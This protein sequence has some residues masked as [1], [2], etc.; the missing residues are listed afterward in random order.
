[1][2]NI[3]FHKGNWA[4]ES[5][6][7]NLVNNGKRVVISAGCQTGGCGKGS[8]PRYRA[9]IKNASGFKG[10]FYLRPNPNKK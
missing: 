5:L 3:L 6:S 9:F 4:R 7:T 1:M 8:L 2:D 10:I